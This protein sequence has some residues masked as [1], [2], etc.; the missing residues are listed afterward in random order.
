MTLNCF[1]LSFLLRDEQL[2]G[3]CSA[4]GGDLV[5]HNSDGFAPAGELKSTLL[6][7]DSNSRSVCAAN[8]WQHQ[9]TPTPSAG[10]SKF[11]VL[12]AGTGLQLPEASLTCLG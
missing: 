2:G 3:A 11:S 6:F 10:G 4:A 8:L 1:S 7:N 5:R 9:R 12:V